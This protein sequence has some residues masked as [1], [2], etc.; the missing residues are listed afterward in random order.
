MPADTLFTYAT[1]FGFLY[2]LARISSVIAFLPLGS[3]R[4]APEPAKIALALGL[5]VLLWPQYKLA[6]FEHVSIGRL[7]AG[8]SGE[9]AV[10]LA[11]GV[12]VSI[13]LEVFQLAAQAVSLQAGFAFASTFDPNSGADSTVLLTAA[14]L[15][16]SLMFFALGA[17]RMLVRVLSDSLRLCPPESFAIQRSWADAMVLFGSSIFGLGLRLAM[18]VIA[19]LLL[20][21]VSLAVFGRIEAHLH[22]VSLAMPVKLG[23]SMFLMAATI[24]YQPRIFADVMNDAIRLIEGMIRSGH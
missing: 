8:I 10:G 13:V 22:L 11:M 16:A 19:L 14:N 1:L 7:V 23:A 12:S 4:G 3:F 2:T 21:D 6:S 24:V 5:T 9:V 18:P 20:V 17:D 15:T